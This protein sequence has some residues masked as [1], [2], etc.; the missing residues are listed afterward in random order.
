MNK[1][2]ISSKDVEWISVH[3]EDVEWITQHKEEFKRLKF[4]LLFIGFLTIG[5]VFG[6]VSGLF[7]PPALIFI[8]TSIFVIVLPGIIVAIKYDAI[9][10]FALY[11]ALAIGFLVSFIISLSFSTSFYSTSTQQQISMQVFYPNHPNITVTQTCAPIKTFASG[12]FNG[13]AINAE[14]TTQ[15]NLPANIAPYNSNPYNCDITEKNIT[16]VSSIYN[17]NITWEG[18]ILKTDLR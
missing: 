17:E 14:S 15:C 8:I 16:C 13:Q 6:F 10:S 12:Y 2:K 5:V 9:D 11:S 4:N 3:K 18:T 7:E 1:S